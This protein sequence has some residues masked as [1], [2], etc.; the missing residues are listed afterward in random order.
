LRKKIDAPG[1]PSFIR[2]E[3]GVGYIF[4]AIP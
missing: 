2:T 4:N 1:E 3:R